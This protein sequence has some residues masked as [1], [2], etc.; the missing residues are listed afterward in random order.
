[1][2]KST[3]PELNFCVIREKLLSLYEDGKVELDELEYRHMLKTRRIN[4]ILRFIDQIK[5]LFCFIYLFVLFVSQIIDV[6]LMI[7]FV[8]AV[9]RI[10]SLTSSIMGLYRIYISNRNIFTDIDDILSFEE[11]AVDS[12]TAITSPPTIEFGMSVIDIRRRTNMPSLMCH[13]R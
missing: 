5:H 1:M 6:S 8:Y 7:T 2:D 10:S 3:A 13:L 11:E 9:F 12:K 4:I